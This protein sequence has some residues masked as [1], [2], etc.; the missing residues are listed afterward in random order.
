[1]CEDHDDLSANACIAY[2]AIISP[3]Q[4]GTQETL[5]GTLRRPVAGA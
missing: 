4:E 5:A 2:P 1:V 3:A